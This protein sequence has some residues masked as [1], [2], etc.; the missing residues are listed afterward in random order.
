MGRAVGPA[1]R[2]GGYDRRATHY[3]G[4]SIRA[5]RED[6]FVCLSFAIAVSFAAESRKETIVATTSSY[7]IAC[8]TIG[9]RV[10]GDDSRMANH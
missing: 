5:G 7:L 4:L 10:R 8:R 3:V 9:S 2:S 1:R 6:R